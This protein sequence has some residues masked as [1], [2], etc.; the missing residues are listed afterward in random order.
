MVFGTFGIREAAGT[1]RLR[2][3]HI[4]ESS[5]DVQASPP[6]KERRPHPLLVLEN[7]VSVV[8]PSPSFFPSWTT[9]S[10]FVSLS[11]GT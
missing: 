9:N 4:A 5:S 8:V 7:S 6:N 11:V 10:L 1:E 3:F 2:N